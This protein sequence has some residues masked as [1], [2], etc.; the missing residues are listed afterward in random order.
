MHPIQMQERPV[1]RRTGGKVRIAS[2]I[3]ERV[4]LLQGWTIWCE[5]FCGSAAVYFRLLQ[6]GAFDRIRAR[7]DYPRV[8]LNDQCA[9]ITNLYRVMREQPEALA[10]AIDHT[11]YSREEFNAANIELPDDSP[12]ERARKYLILNWQGFAG[13]CDGK[14]WGFGKGKDVSTDPIKTWLGI[15]GRIRLAIEPFQDCYIEHQDFEPV[16]K[17]WDSPHTLFYLDPPYWDTEGYYDHPFGRED[18]LRLAKL[19]HEVEGQVI[20]SYYPHA[21]IEALYSPDEWDFLYKDTMLCTGKVKANEG[22]KRG[23]RTE[24]LLIRKN[25][26]EYNIPTSDCYQ[27]SL[28]DM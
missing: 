12:L 22:D 26:R 2:W 14:S 21:E 28:F 24:L 17:R 5:P 9:K 25:R 27:L 4:A 20:L 7:G 23:R 10:Y 18:H 3:A 8:V 15:A 13:T 1:I 6:L 16:M 19:A 11:P